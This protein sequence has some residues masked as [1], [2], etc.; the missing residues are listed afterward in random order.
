MNVACGMEM[1]I[2]G[3]R[4]VLRCMLEMKEK[5]SVRFRGEERTRSRN[6]METEWN[7]YTASIMIIQ[8][9]MFLFF[10]NNFWVV[11]Y[12]VVSLLAVRLNNALIRC[13]Y[14]PLCPFGRVGIRAAKRGKCVA[15]VRLFYIIRL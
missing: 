14:L 12:S 2:S 9:R 10:C 4:G 1:S 13:N 11:G 7:A 5:C 15:L 6:E 3:S 8:P